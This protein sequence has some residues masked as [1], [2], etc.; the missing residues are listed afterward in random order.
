VMGG[1]RVSAAGGD[2]TT[3]AGITGQYINTTVNGQ[4]VTDGRYTTGIYSTTRISPD[5]V[6]EI[7]LI[8]TPVDAELGRGNGQV[9]IQTRSGTNKYTGS[10]VWNVRNSALNSNT[11]SNNRAIDGAT[12]LW[13]PTIRNWQNNHQFTGS[14]GGPIL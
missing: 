14:F 8:L 6:G 12:G 1:A 10:V 2:L 3:F 4:S 7:R 11:W 13:K 5:L 9:Q